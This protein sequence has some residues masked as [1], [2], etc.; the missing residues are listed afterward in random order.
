MRKRI[1]RWLSLLVVALAVGAP[2]AFPAPARAC[3]S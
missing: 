3:P 2:V 1:T